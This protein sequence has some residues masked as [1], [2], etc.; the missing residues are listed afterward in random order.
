MNNR[1]TLVCML[2]VGNAEPLSSIA[3]QS[4]RNRF[5]GVVL[6]GHISKSD[7]AFSEQDPNVEYL[8]LSS[9]LHFEEDTYRGFQD[10]SF[11]QIVKLKWEL[12]IHALSMGFDNVIYTDLDLLWLRDAA[13]TI[14]RTF[15]KFTSIEILIQ[16]F[17]RGTELPCLCMGFVALRVNKRNQEFVELC[18][19]THENIAVK[20]PMIGD[21][22]VVSQVFQDLNYPSWIRELPQSTFPTGNIYPLYIKHLRFRKMARVHPYVFH[23]NYV[24]GIENKLLLL[25]YLKYFAFL[26]ID[27]INI[28]TQ[29][30]I[31][32]RILRKKILTTKQI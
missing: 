11:Y 7:V 21:D 1:T 2:V 12:I 27:S 14:E 16:S 5:S 31:F 3:F 9:K 26:K 24:V 6:I 8:D 25:V 17:T 10:P 22:E 28:I 29:L 19:R 15:Q 23:L 20:N 32:I 13:D 4:I 18:Q 30:K